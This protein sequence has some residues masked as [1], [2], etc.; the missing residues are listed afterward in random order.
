MSLSVQLHASSYNFGLDWDPNTS[1]GSGNGN[2]RWGWIWGGDN[3]WHQEHTWLYFNYTNFNALHLNWSQITAV[4]FTTF[5][6]D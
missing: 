5:P 6:K 2:G 3:Q 1:Y 4:D